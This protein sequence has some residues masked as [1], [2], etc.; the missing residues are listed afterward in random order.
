MKSALVTGGAG[1]IGSHIC[2]QLIELN[3]EVLVVDNLITGSERNINEKCQFFFGSI[4]NFVESQK[5]LE[6]EANIIFHT[7]ALSR[8]Q[9]SFADPIKHED[10]NVLESLRLFEA[11]YAREPTRG[12]IY[13]SSSAV[14]G[15]PLEIPTTEAAAIN[16]LSPYASQKFSAE[17]QLH[18][19]GAFFNFPVVSLRYFNPYGP[20]SYNSSNP[21]AEYTSVI[22]VFED[23]LN[24][25]KPLVITGDGTQKRDFV[26]VQDVARANIFFGMNIEKFANEKFNIGSGKAYSILEVAKLMSKDLVFTDAR[27]G[28]A[29]TTLA[30]VTK[31]NTAGWEAKLDLEEYIH[32]LV[33]KKF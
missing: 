10:A 27:Q 4:S 13:S 22:G 17:S 20:R 25:K 19:L 18:Q 29:V 23:L 28:E 6:F 12:I 3:F 15:N 21:H 11:Y 2:D 7:A 32:G 5:F 8:I 24:K 16:P 30:D 26:H 33:R 31:A 14:Y 1:F 9:P